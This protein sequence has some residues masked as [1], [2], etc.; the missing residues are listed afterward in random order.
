MKRCTAVD[1]AIK[2]LEHEMKVAERVLEKSFV[3]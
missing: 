1:I 3:E 2:I